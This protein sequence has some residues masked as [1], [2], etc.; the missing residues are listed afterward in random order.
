MKNLMISSAAL[1]LMASGAVAGGLDRSGQSMGDLYQEGNVA[2]LSFGQV[3]PSISGTG[4]GIAAAGI[5]AG[6][7]YDGVG[8]H[9]TAYALS[10]K[11]DINERLSFAIINDQP[12][13][14]DVLYP[15]SGTTTELG[16]TRATVDTRATTF[17]GRYK[18]DGG[19][20]AH[21]GLRIQSISGEIDL[22]GIAYG[23]PGVTPTNANGYKLVAEQGTELGYLVGVA[24]ER[25]DIA[26]RVSL[27]YN[28]AIDYNLDATDSGG[29]FTSGDYTLETSTPESWNLEFQ[30]GVAADTLVFGSIRW[31]AWGDFDVP[32]N[33]LAGSDLA[34][35]DDSYAYTLGVG[36]RF[37]DK[38]SGSV[39]LSYEAEGD[40]LVSPLAPTNGLMGITV[41]A[42]Y[43]LNETV[44]LSGGVNYTKLGDAR[45]ETGSTERAQFTDNDSLGV[46]FSIAY[47]F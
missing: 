2:K 46:G 17:V 8:E 25:P 4:S 37:N 18:F 1:A 15:G 12:F 5:A 27:T 10:L 39:S 21:A 23:V 35:I 42:Q 9:Y 34:D 11:M 38:L 33:G 26:L 43:A 31:A 13:G 45:P 14:V 47:K 40:D 3:N 19:L 22:S 36:R 20:S 7:A 30:T 6:T 32:A 28:S 16:G 29:F 44:T 41:G 24:Y